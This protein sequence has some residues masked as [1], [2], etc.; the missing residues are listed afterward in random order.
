MFRFDEVEL[1]RGTIGLEAC[2]LQPMLPLGF[3]FATLLLD[4]VCY[5]QTDIEGCRLDGRESQPAHLDIECARSQTL[6]EG[7][8]VLRPLASARVPTVVCPRTIAHPHATAAPTAEHQSRKERRSTANHPRLRCLG[9]VGLKLRDILFVLPPR[10]VRR[11]AVVEADLP[12][13][14]AGDALSGARSTRLL[15][16]WIG[17][18]SPIDVRSG[19]DGIVEDVGQ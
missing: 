11:Q 8:P 3:H 6:A 14:R 1:A 16:P 18:V 13:T 5:A 17:W 2:P 7:A 9:L 15:S 10:D 12:L 19:V 4:V